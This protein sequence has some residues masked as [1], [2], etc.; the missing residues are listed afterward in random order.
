MPVSF[1]A[2]RQGD[3]SSVLKKTLKTALL[4][5]SL[6]SSD[7]SI[8]LSYS[9]TRTTAFFPVFSTA[10]TSKCLNRSSS[11]ASLLS[12]LRLFN[13][14]FPESYQAA[15]ASSAA[16]TLT[17][18]ADVSTEIYPSL[19]LASSRSSSII[20]TLSTGASPVEFTDVFPMKTP[21]GN[22]AL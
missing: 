5:S 17:P 18:R 14:S 11:G 13:F 6:S 2:I 3:G 7:S 16:P 22:V 9:S 1:S 20:V 12:S 19:A 21:P 8:A 15:S 10:F 4:C